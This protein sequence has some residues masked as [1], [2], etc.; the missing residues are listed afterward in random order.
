MLYH[1]AT[2]SQSLALTPDGYQPASAADA[3]LHRLQLRTKRNPRLYPAQI[4]LASACLER[5]KA[6][7]DANAVRCARDAAQASLTVQ[8]TFEGYAILAAVE[9]FSHHFDA[10][11]DAASRAAGAYPESGSM[12]ALRVECLIGSGRLSEAR[13]LVAAASRPPES[14]ASPNAYDFYLRLAVAALARADG[15]VQTA[16]RS[17]RKAA[18][19]AARQDA[20]SLQTWSLVQAAGLL[21]D[22]GRVAAASKVLRAA[23]DTGVPCPELEAHYAEFLAARGHHVDALRV[24]RELMTTD[25]LPE[26]RIQ[27]WRLAV[28][29]PEPKLAQ[30]LFAQAEV[31]LNNPLE[32]GEIYTAEMLARLYLEAGAHG[33]KLCE[34]AQRNFEFK[35]DAAAVRLLRD[36]EKVAGPCPTSGASARSFHVANGGKEL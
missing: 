13:A 10:C 2:R 3:R 26:L 8:E 11:L 32:A 7:L 18:T 34:L 19:M 21:L 24:Y 27:A 9:A 31:A 17:H 25:A 30:E 16:V 14:T 29:L 23:R 35:K 20:T 1:G 6:T 4:A 5:A 22:A 36:I 33:D 12:L 15:R 28:A